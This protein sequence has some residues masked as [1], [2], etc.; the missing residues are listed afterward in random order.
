MI[1]VFAIASVLAGTGCH[2]IET[3]KVHGRDL[4]AALPAFEALPPD[5]D[6][7][8]APNPGQQRTFRIGEL[9]RIAIANHLDFEPVENVCFAWPTT[10][11]D[12]DKILE[13]MGKTLVDRKA[14]VEIIDQSR[15]GAPAGDLVFPMSGISGVS[16][17]P[18]VWHGY[19][20]YAGERRFPIWARVRITVHEKR[21]KA[22]ETLRPGLPVQPEQVRVDTY[23]G[24]LTRDV[25]PS[26]LKSV[27]GMI[28]RNTIPADTFVLASMLSVPEDVQRGDTV[29]VVVEMTNGHIEAQGI[30]E[31]GGMRGSV[32]IV[33][34][35]KSGRTFRARIEDRGKVVVIPTGSPGLPSEDKGL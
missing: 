6:L 25:A 1:A 26:T 10:V 24:P 19:V 2:P 30:A 35:A 28:P 34:N 3:E 20:T 7:G 23:E 21:V 13:A 12:R 32:I 33:R 11:P 5:S 15:T 31:G 16:S 27:I 29:Q 22:I 18:V 14:T 9:R 4:A 8:Y 17:A